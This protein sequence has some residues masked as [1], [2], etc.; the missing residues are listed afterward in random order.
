MLEATRI[1]TTAKIAV[2]YW[3]A[4]VLLLVGY[5]AFR[6][7]HMPWTWLILAVDVS[8]L[9]VCVKVPWEKVP[10]IWFVSNYYVGVV[11]TVAT[12]FVF[13]LPAV[14]WMLFPI[15][16]V[17]ANVYWGRKAALVLHVVVIYGVFTAATL[18]IGGHGETE[19]IAIGVPIMIA[20]I[21]SGAYMA[22]RF[23]GLSL[24][25]TRFRA[26][27]TSLLSALHARDGYTAEHSK[28]TLE[29]VLGVA[30]QLDLPAAEREV[31]ADMALLHDIGKIGI[32]NKI[33]NK[34]GGLSD[35][36]WEI[37]RQHP[38][39]G[40][41]ILADVQGFE[42]VSRAIRHEHERWDGMGYPDGL[43]GRE[44]P[45]A[46]RIVLACDAYHAMTS[47]RPYRKAMS[48]KHARDELLANAG[49]QFDPTVVDALIQL[50]HERESE[51]TH[52]VAGGPSA[53]VTL[54][55]V[56]SQRGNGGI[57]QKPSSDP[58]APRAA[59]STRGAMWREVNRGTA[60]A[61]RQVF[62][63]E[64]NA[65]D[66]SSDHDLMRLASRLA[67][68]DWVGSA[69]VACVF[70]ALFRGIDWVGP[71]L[72]AI[73]LVAGF[74]CVFMAQR[75]DSNY[76]VLAGV[77]TAAVVT[78]VA[79]S[80]FHQPALV[81]LVILSTTQGGV[82]WSERRLFVAQ[83]VIVMALFTVVPYA[84]GGNAE[85]VQIPYAVLAFPTALLLQ[86]LVRSRIP[87]MQFERRRFASTATSLLVALAARD[88][89]TAEHSQETVALA[90]DVADQ[91]AIEP[92]AKRR[93]IDIAL[94]HDIGKIGI[95][96]EVLNKT[97]PFNEEQWAIMREHPVI[98]ERIVAQVPGF[99]AVAT[100]IRHEHER[101]DGSGY[102]D[103]LS[104]EQIPLA[105][106]IVLVCDS[107]HAM[108]SDRPYRRSIGRQAARREMD[109]CSGSQFDP[110]VVDALLRALD[111]QRRQ[112]VEEST[113]RP[114]DGDDSLQAIGARGA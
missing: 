82:F 67:L 71:I 108:T 104:G 64:S 91:L 31:L 53:V 65:H 84:V 88:G 18:A 75:S 89:Y 34:A 56:E 114:H 6:T 52:D 101:W 32:P 37:M 97:G 80:H 76:A 54:G 1:R 27:I 41:Q 15:S 10:A 58:V 62:E 78:A 33:L 60:A 38:V 81:L 68:V 5:A 26:T 109:R 11:T 57:V 83:G 14:L 69:V 8:M 40:A 16:S 49:S 9:V 7:S 48:A 36:E 23:A 43:A 100:A 72:L 39:I 55:R 19:R 86:G 112:V 111:E 102:P 73:Y 22:S 93:L 2:L 44:I 110:M 50:L 66:R 92:A 87:K 13:D 47:D 96:D 3:A 42:N 90:L 99:E 95:P 4:S 51:P 35:Q 29:M 61:S 28:K 79:A 98:G 45:L 25:H 103:G 94:L 105:S 21:L 24:H 20:S 59:E 113:L 77:F 106:R 17:L 70:V 74:V 63:V 107:F 85:L 46:S 30:D 12:A